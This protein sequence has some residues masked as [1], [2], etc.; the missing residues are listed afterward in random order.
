MAPASPIP[1]VP[2]CKW[3]IQGDQACSRPSRVTMFTIE[4]CVIRCMTC[5]SEIEANELLG[6]MDLTDIHFFLVT[7][8]DLHVLYSQSDPVPSSTSDLIP[9]QL[10]DA[11]HRCVEAISEYTRRTKQFHPVGTSPPG[12]WP[13]LHLQPESV[14]PYPLKRDPHLEHPQKAP[15]ACG[16]SGVIDI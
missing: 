12:N 6:R 2:R 4:E 15:I 16:S 3:L 14:P 7:I 8:L 1:H 11:S 5:S 13:K 9:H 10:H